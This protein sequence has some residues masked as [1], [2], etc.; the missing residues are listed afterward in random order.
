MVSQPDETTCG[1]SC[2]HSVYQYFDDRIPLEQVIDEV[3]S[4]KSGG[5]LEVFL[6]CH[7]LRRGYSANIYTYNLTIFDPTWFGL[8][9]ADIRGKLLK[10]MEEKDDPK[11]HTATKGYLDFL[12]LGGELRMEDLTASLIR[13]YLKRGIPVLVGLS[14]TYLYGTPREHG[15]DG[16]F[17]DIRGRSAG[18]FVVLCGYDKETRRVLV[19][20]PLT[21][22]PLS[23][24]HYYEIGIERVVCSILLGVLSYDAN[25]LVISPRKRRTA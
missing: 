22:S 2:L 5:T 3:R 9:R 13:K 14:S 20:D 4:L 25:L 17:D 11:L 21:P 1:P 12:G 7:A 16:D 6:A 19:A 18:H 15:H 24:S 10:Q 8:P 23:M